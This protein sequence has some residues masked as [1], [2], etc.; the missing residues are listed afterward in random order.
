M[1]CTVW[2]RHCGTSHRLWVFMHIYVYLYRLDFLSVVMLVYHID[3]NKSQVNHWS[4]T[5]TVFVDFYIFQWINHWRP[6]L[7]YL[8]LNVFEHILVYPSVY[9]SA[10]HV[11]IEHNTWYWSFNDKPDMLYS[12]D[13]YSV[14]SKNIT[15]SLI[16]LKTYNNYRY[17]MNYL[18]KRNSI[19]NW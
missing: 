13:V 7:A 4:K 3:I 17:L 16:T 8:T 2:Y 6:L 19:K 15:E 1:S 10:C 5:I 11:Q 12:I 9:Q 18:L 14:T